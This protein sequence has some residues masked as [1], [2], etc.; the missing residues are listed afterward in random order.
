MLQE[1]N[2][3]TLPQASQPD[4]KSAATQ[5]AGA[6]ADK[7]ADEAGGDVKKARDKVEQGG[8]VAAQV[9]GYAGVAQQA[10]SL[11][12]KGAGANGNGKA[13]TETD[14]NAPTTNTKVSNAAAIASNGQFGVAHL[15]KL[16]IVVEGKQIAHYK[17]FQLKQSAI[18]HHTFSLVLDHD[19]LGIA[20]DHQMEQAQKLM[21]KRVLVTF[22]YKNLLSGSPER[23]FV[24]VITKVT[25]SRAH[26]SRGHIILD[27]SSP[28]LLLDAAPH[29]QSFGGVQP[30]SLSTLAQTL[31]KEGLGTKYKFRVKPNFTGNLTYS[32][33]YDETHYNYLARMAEAYGEQF[34]YDGNMIHFG[35]LPDS[36]KAIVLTFG[37]DVEEVQIAMRTKHLNRTMYGYNSSSH[38]ILTTGQTK[39][40]HKSSLAK[41]AYEISEKTFQTPSLRMAP[42]KAITDKNVEAAQQ[43]T[44]G[45]QAAAVLVTTG[46]TSVP[47][48]Y[49]GCVVDMNMRKPDSADTNYFTRLMITDV[50]H[51]VDKLGNYTGYFEAIAEGTGYLPTPAF[52]TPIAEPQIA[53]VTDNK[54]DKGRVQVK[55]DWQN[56]GGTTEWIRVMSPDAGGSEKVSKN[57]G[58]MAIPEVGDQVMVGFVYNHPDRPYVM[59]GLYHGKVGGGGGSG[60]NIKSLSSKSGH[61]VELNDGGGI[62]VRDKTGG[63]SVVIDGNDTITVTSSKV[64]E[65][66]NGQSSIKMDGTKITIYADEIE[67]AKSGGLSS[68]IEIKG[69][70]TSISGKNSMKMLSD[71]MAEVNSKGTTDIKA[72]AALTADAATTT[73]KATGITTV[74]GGI[75]NIN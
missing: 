28:T 49:P 45:S 68:K 22:T 12:A 44:T 21:G 11:L 69:L 30:V 9:A 39:I 75:V 40:T 56:G 31:L 71:T 10:G 26:G 51:A 3:G 52:S 60:N 64:V 33:Q 72:T 24:G 43:S 25:Y 53:T 73:V 74:Q 47:F 15:T 55:F 59:G 14:K 50:N 46:K 66:T 65:L 6:V 2:K 23:D 4:M 32:C 1:P 61:I 35:K 19:A 37:K 36:E 17:H 7:A 34:Y 18:T 41:A 38:E 58:F 63:N 27:G 42:L 13:G 70:D 8:K 16:T 57:R 20:D 54:D 67:V 5:A 29:I 48:L 62:T